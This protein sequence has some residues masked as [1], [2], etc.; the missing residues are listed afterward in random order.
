MAQKSKQ[1]E[2][3]NFEKASIIKKASPPKRKPLFYDQISY[4]QINMLKTIK[5]ESCSY[6]QRTE[7]TNIRAVL[8]PCYAE[9]G[10]S[11]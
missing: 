4:E 1:H 6:A 3:K 5:L 10:C 8:I 7:K 11:I 9:I 2:E